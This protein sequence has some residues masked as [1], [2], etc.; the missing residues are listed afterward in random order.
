MAPLNLSP[1]TPVLICGMAGAAGGWAEAGYL[2]APAAFAAL[3]GAAI[4][5]DISGRDIRILPGMSTLTPAPDVMRGEE[6]QL[7]GLARDSETLVCLPGTHSKWALC[8]GN[9]LRSFTTYMTGEIYEVMANHSLLA[10]MLDEGWDAE[11]FATAVREALEAPAAVW[12]RF[13]GLRASAVLGEAVPASARARLSGLLIGAE[14][15]A[16]RAQFGSGV[17]TL[18]AGGVMAQSYTIALEAAGF[19]VTLRDS[20]E[21]TSR[22]LIR[23][24]QDIW[25][26]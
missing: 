2:R 1:E 21:V 10:R 20:D 24:A 18:V 17:A 11:S 12:H 16:A 23:A 4:R 22:G 7:M 15:A 19:A 13:F 5:L 9:G 26:F 6:T 25:R 8:A 3:A 14:V